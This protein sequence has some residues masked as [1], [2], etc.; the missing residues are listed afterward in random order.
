M[1]QYTILKN[2]CLSLLAQR[3]NTTE[4]ILMSL[5]SDQIKN[6]DLIYEGDKL[7]LPDPTIDSIPLDGSRIELPQAPEE[8][9]GG[10]DTCSGPVD[11]VDILYIPAHPKTGEKCWYAITQ[12][13]KQIIEQEKALLEKV[14]VE[15]DVQTTSQNLNQLGVLSKFSTKYFEQFM[16][17]DMADDYK[18]L[19]LFRLVLTFHLYKNL[20]DD[21][22]VVLY[23][24]AEKAHIKYDDLNLDI[25]VK[26]ILKGMKAFSQTLYNRTS[27]TEYL[28]LNQIPEYRQSVLLDNLHNSVLNK[29]T[30]TIK[31]V[32]K[33]TIIQAENMEADDGTH[34][35]YRDELN[36]FTSIRQDVLEKYM[37]E[38]FSLHSEIAIAQL[39]HERA[40]ERLIATIDF[41]SSAELH[42][43]YLF[44]KVI[45]QLGFVIKEQCLTREQLEGEGPYNQGPKVLNEK[46]PNWRSPNQV[47]DIKNR[48]LIN[49]LYKQSKGGSVT[50]VTEALVND[51]TLDWSYYP[52]LALIAL[53]DNTINEHQKNLAQILGTIFPLDNI[54]YKLLWIKKVAKSRIDFLKK[55]AQS[56]LK[57]LNPT[58]EFKPHKITAMPAKLTL[59]WDYSYKA[60]IK[61]K[62]GFKNQA[63]L[64]DLQVVECSLMSTGKLFYLR[65][66]AWYMPE[67]N[68]DDFCLQAKGHVRNITSQISFVKV[69]ANSSMPEMTLP[70]AL[71]KLKTPQ[72]NLNLYPLTHRKEFNTAFWS[73]GWHYQD[74]IS[75]DGKEAQYSIDAG[76]QLFRFSAQGARLLNSSLTTYHNAIKEPK[77][78]GG[79]RG[80]SA[81]L[82]LLQ[83]QASIK[84]WLP[85]QKNNVG[86]KEV[87]DTSGFEIKIP[88]VNSAHQENIYSAGFFAAKIEGSIYGLAG[89]SCM[90]SS[91]LAFGPSDINGS[92]FGIRGCSVTAFD[93]NVRRVN[94]LISGP[95]SSKYTAETEMIIDIF[96]G[97]EAGGN[98]D[99]TVYWK[100]SK[101]NPYQ[102]LGSINGHL[103]VAYGIG[104]Q[105]GFRLLFQGGVLVLVASAKMVVGPGASGRFAI[106]LDMLGV[107]QFINTLLG[108]LKMHDFKHLSIFGDVDENG[109]NEDFELL[110]SLLTFSM[111][112]GLSVADVLLMPISIWSEG[113]QSILSKEYAPLLA[114]NLNVRERQ[115]IMKPW[116]TKLP[117]ET[118]CNLFNSLIK[119]QT[120]S[121]SGEL[122]NQSQAQAILTIMEYLAH[123]EKNNISSKRQWK[124]SLIR[125]NNNP[126]ILQDKLLQWESF[127]DNWFKLAKFVKQFSKLG[128]N[129]T[130]KTRFDRFSKSLCQKMVLTY[131]DE[132]KREVTGSFYS[133]IM[134]YQTVHTEKLN[135][136]N[137]HAYPISIVVNP[138]ARGEVVQ[139]RNVDGD[140][141]T[142]QEF[143]IDW[144][145]N[146]TLS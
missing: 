115:P 146:D 103:S 144:T 121:K 72:I 15:G 22:I 137:Y 23:D 45:N 85:L 11:F 55:V 69:R 18:T 70:T 30:D 32:E 68:S 93:P 6:P 113:E 67:N 49:E 105:A 7:T 98:L 106:N 29:I 78:L 110:N 52:S 59:Q 40:L 35:I 44:L 82:S 17:E 50:E 92:N 58:L 84:F 145:I 47:I 76:A 79:S 75:P 104:G 96:A 57:S 135:V 38:F 127:K 87:K 73:D 66:P 99:A 62:A 95:I 130:I 118:L 14:I 114:H 64:N 129:T 9:A 16:P 34:F 101:S 77:Y 2:D 125:M 112:M 48:A 24:M 116:V 46:M 111:I 71:K 102:E 33:W 10:A 109:K 122:N 94:K 134:N 90:L 60:K 1:A 124:E 61:K 139:V 88:Y 89:A 65:G 12:E 53:I 51:V 128:D 107:D 28:T 39:P 83:A 20:K 120:D 19:N 119:E 43:L 126:S 25:S 31:R 54:F 143:I 142:K 21:P 42:P 108:I 4:E 36:Y 13:A 27:F 123:D 5:N 140:I 41:S 133:S 8:L 81:Q 56:R 26:K 3:F 91:K 136:R 131:S 100:P 141:E 63:K 97:V 80:I 117:P 37:K 132:I 138:L 86:I 74:G